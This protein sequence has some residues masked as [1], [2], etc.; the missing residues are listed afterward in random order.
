[1]AKDDAAAPDTPPGE[2]DKAGDRPS[3]NFIQQIIDADVAEDRH[4]RVGIHTRF[5][6][7]PNGY[8]HIGHAKSILLNS[9]LAT[10]YG[11]KFNL[12]F[13]DTNPAKEE[14]EYV[15]AIQ[16]DVR[17]LGADWENRLFYA[18]DYFE[19]LFGWAKE[20]IRAGHAYVCDLSADEMREL[21][22]TLTEP[23][24][25]SPYRDRPA[26]ESLKLFQQMREGEFADGAKT[27][28]AKID[29]AS[30]NVNLRDPVMY[31]IKHAHHQRTGDDWPIYPSYDWTHGQSDAMEGITHSI[32]TLEFENH[33]PLYDWFCDRLEELKL[34]PARPRQIEFA[35]LNLTYTVMSKRK[36]LQLVTEGHVAGWDDPRMPTI[37]GLRR[38][39][40]TSEAVRA[41]CERIGVA[42]FNSTIDRL[43]LEDAVREH[44]NRTALRRMAVI[45]PL[46]VVLTDVD[47]EVAKQCQLDNHPQDPEQGVRTV[48]LGRVLYIERD[49]FME[50][51]PKKF[52]RLK[53]GGSV[54][55]RGA[56]IATCQEVIKD[57]EG[58]V[59]E[60]RCTFI[61]DTTALVDGKKV[62]GT[63]H[64][65]DAATCHDC[66]VRLYDHLFKTEN[67]DKAPEGGDFLDNLNPDSLRTVTA[68]VEPTVAEAEPGE[69]LQFERLGYFYADP[70]D[71]K[72]GK[73]SFNRTVTLRD[74]WS[75]AGGSK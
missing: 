7:E 44:L 16:E 59:A 43:W 61:P 56:G 3:R 21:R 6:P 42:K 66:T 58:R 53:P 25:P 69:R 27:L 52:F 8:L 19:T 41:F 62:K 33:R 63:I 9:G 73:P 30:P 39:G 24:K 18:S 47:G 14:Q 17:W 26:E 2:G 29:M 13:D 28:R 75:K 55:L 38:R 46:R 67:P 22:G 49:D 48:T 68:K 54:R 35:R 50:E 31:R 37:R 74:T 64:W 20:L 5:P 36:L 45:D 11:G 57:D 10:E 12:R 72:P 4:T 71:S 51:A 40:Y 23:G 15:D 60:L 65:V 34:L 1:M 32:C 70:I